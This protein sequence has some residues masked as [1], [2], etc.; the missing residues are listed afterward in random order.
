[1]NNRKICFFL[2][3]VLELLT[4]L[5]LEFITDKRGPLLEGIGDAQFQYIFGLICALSAIVSAFLAIKKKQLNPFVR[6]AILMSGVNMILF[7]YY[8]FY[9]TNLLYFLPLL[10]IAYMFI[11]PATED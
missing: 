1:M 2:F 4:A 9:D 8:F 5:L 7:D 6:M 10:A 3:I 11:W